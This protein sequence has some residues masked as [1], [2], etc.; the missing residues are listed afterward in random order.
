MHSSQTSVAT[1]VLAL[2]GLGLALPAD[3][4][5]DDFTISAGGFAAGVSGVVPLPT[6]VPVSTPSLKSSEITYTHKAADK[7]ITWVPLQPT[8]SCGLPPNHDNVAGIDAT[9]FY[10]TFTTLTTAIMPPKPA[11]ISPIFPADPT[12]TSVTTPE[13][14][15]EDADALDKTREGKCTGT[16]GRCRVRVK[17]IPVKKECE[18][19]TQC[20][21]KG[22]RCFL[23][24][25]TW[26]RYHVTCT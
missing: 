4:H 14:H 1:T 8:H 2:T 20:S 7:P 22:S 17:G 10:G 15:E 12:P 11:I 21:A 16:S 18:D 24:G 23:S 9:T 26:A 19:G 13:E 5:Q 3:S 25:R 6:L